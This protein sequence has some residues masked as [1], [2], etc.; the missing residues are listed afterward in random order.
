MKKNIIILIASVLL[1]VSPGCE[2]LNNPGEIKTKNSLFFNL[3]V[4]S[5]QQHVYIYRNPDITGS[6]EY[7]AADPYVNFFNKD[8]EIT[9]KD[10]LNGQSTSFKLAQDTLD[11]SSYYTGYSYSNP[12]RPYYTNSVALNAKPLRDYFLSVNADGNS[13]TGKVT[14]PGDFEIVSPHEGEVVRGQLNLAKFL[15]RWRS[16]ENAKG[17]TVRINVI[18]KNFNKPVWI[19]FVT[20]DTSKDLQSLSLLMS[21]FGSGIYTLQVIAFDENYFQH[22]YNKKE[23]VGLN[24]A[25]GCFSSSVVK[26]VRFRYI[27]D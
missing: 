17:Y 1:I 24:G 2:D 12:Y 25:Y 26:E 14:T 8:A 4:N 6:M 3:Q 7:N 5:P 27:S 15:F 23:I 11:G 9:L 10:M 20:Y 18:E 21:I 19:S 22:Y 16:S 13:I